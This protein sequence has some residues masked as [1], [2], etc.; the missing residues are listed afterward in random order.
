MT[1]HWQTT[2]Y[3]IDLTRPR[4][5]GIVNV[6]PDSF[7][8]GGAHGTVSAALVHCE[9]LLSEGADILDIGGESS[10][11]GAA[12][13]PAEEELRRVLPVL[14]GALA[15]GCPV[16]VD[17]AKSEVMR[18]ALDLGA[19]IVNDILALRAGGALDLVAG[20]P[21]C[22]VCLMHMQGE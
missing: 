6:T 21:G 5:M 2:R 11:P 17:T 18:A 13:V 19:D 10:R 9:R 1:T 3:S 22:G 16:S 14:K 7:S 8:D 12:S 20:H 15:L 4:V